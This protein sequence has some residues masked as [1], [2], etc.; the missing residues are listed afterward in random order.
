MQQLPLVRSHLRRSMLLSILF[1]FSILS[2][3]GEV[4]L[5]RRVSLGLAQ[6]WSVFD[7]WG[8]FDRT[9]IALTPGGDVLVF[10]ARRNGNWELYRARGW[11][12]ERASVE[13]LTL[14]GYFSTKDQRDLDELTTHLF[15]TKDGAYAVCVGDAWWLKRV[16]GNAVGNSRADN[17]V[18]VVDL[19]TLKIANRIH[20]KDL[21]LFDEFQEVRLDAN[22]RIL[23]I[24][25]P[26]GHSQRG[27]FVQLAI[28]SLIPGAK[29]EY[30]SVPDKTA[31]THAVAATDESCQKAL[32]PVSLENYL[33]TDQPIITRDPPFKCTNAAAEYCPQPY[34][35]TRDQRFG[36]GLRTEGHDALFGGWVET[37]AVAVIFS[38]KTR[39]EIGELDLDKN[40]DTG[41]LLE[42]VHERIYL[43]VLRNSTELGVYEVSGSSD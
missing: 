5:L 31:T 28:P 32:G 25:S 30:N 20:T 6:H 38:T 26:L 39:S 36:L 33:A 42:S 41:P 22:G 27:A 17:I 13:R 15:V 43:L 29:C 14:D 1:M 35:F 2:A 3:H 8:S 9:A 24:G 37:R 21:H 34:E 7:F 16:H 40:R 23:V 4:R 12:T 11:N 18:A 19:A 10:S